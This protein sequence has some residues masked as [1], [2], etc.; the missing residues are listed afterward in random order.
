MAIRFPRITAARRQAALADAEKEF[1]RSDK[2]R[3]KAKH[4]SIRTSQIKERLEL[5]Q[6]REFSYGAT[7]VDPD[8][9]KELARRIG[10]HGELDPVL[11]I[12]LGKEWVCVDG[13]HRIAAYRLRNHKKPI[14]CEWFPGTPKEAVDESM[15]RNKKDTLSISSADRHEEAW[16]RMLLNQG[17]KKEISDDCGVSTSTIANMRKAK[18]RYESD[19]EYAGLVGRPLL[20]TSWGVMKLAAYSKDAGEFDLEERASVLA[21][22]LSRRMTDLLK[23][24][25]IVTA[26]ALAK[27]DSRLP[28]ALMDVWNGQTAIPAARNLTEPEMKKQAEVM[29][30]RADAIDAE[31]AKREEVR[32]LAEA[33]ERRGAE[34]ARM[35]RFSYADDL[36]R[37]KEEAT[38]EAKLRFPEADE[39]WLS[40]YYT[41]PTDNFDV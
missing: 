11:I 3:G 2:T 31:L 22:T 36:R 5:F 38:K 35:R 17:S 39:F 13:H 8:W 18:R 32:A 30:R 12:R 14:K 9:V 21:R 40:L 4:V 19:P 15:Q 1:A 27:Y 6:P 34:T 23:R 25:P 24:H 37:R 29:R 10:I 41:P 33:E 28:R 26:Y 16:R 7:T 20:E